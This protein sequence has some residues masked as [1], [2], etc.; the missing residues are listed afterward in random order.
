MHINIFLSLFLVTLMG[1]AGAQ[2]SHG[3]L[4]TDYGSVWR[5]SQGLCVWTTYWGG[6][7]PECEPAVVNEAVK[8]EPV[9]MPAQEVPEIVD[10]GLLQFDFDKSDLK[11]ASIAELNRLAKAIPVLDAGRIEIDGHT[12]SIGTDEYNQGLSNRRADS[13]KSYLIQQG[14]SEDLIET[15]GFGETRPAYS[16]DTVE[17]RSLNRRVEIRLLNSSSS[18][19]V[20]TES[21]LPLLR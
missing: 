20:I 10:K 19:Q 18:Q 7:V 14:I 11:P 5:D 2:T 16:N 21:T 15:H 1:N 6:D 17:N 9:V 13:A 12:C 4:L 3:Y 8:P